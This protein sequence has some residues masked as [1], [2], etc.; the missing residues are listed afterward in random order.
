M[1]YIADSIRS[2][3]SRRELGPQ[4]QACDRYSVNIRCCVGPVLLR[5]GF[6]DGYGV[7]VV[8]AGVDGDGV[9]PD[10]DALAFG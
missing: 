9:A 2:A 7:G 5:S 6:G 1:A 10:C 3:S 8:G 4:P